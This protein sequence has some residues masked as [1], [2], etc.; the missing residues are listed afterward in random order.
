MSFPPAT[1]L[2][3]SRFIFPDHGAS[4]GSIRPIGLAAAAARASRLRTAV[5]LRQ[6]RA[7]IAAAEQAPFGQA[8]L[9]AVDPQGFAAHQRFRYFVPRICYDAAEGLA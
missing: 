2:P 5:S 7:A 1:V 6:W 9:A 3:N 8:E 4:R